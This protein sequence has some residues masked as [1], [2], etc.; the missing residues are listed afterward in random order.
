LL[1]ALPP[2]SRRENRISCSISFSC[3]ALELRENSV[4]R[5][6]VNEDNVFIF[7]LRQT[8]SQ[9]IEGARSESD[10]FRAGLDG[11]QDDVVLFVK[12]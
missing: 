8:V 9:E 7:V 4:R 1:N 2:D 12:I 11:N 5:D 3:L 6:H 10:F